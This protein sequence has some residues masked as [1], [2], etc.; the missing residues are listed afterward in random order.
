MANIVSDI[1]IKQRPY[2]GKHILID[3][4]IL[5]YQL[6]GQLDLSDELSSCASL[7]IS[8][9]TVT[10]LYAGTESEDLTDM[11][12]F[13]SEFNVLPLTKE[14][15]ELAGMYAAQLESKKYKDYLIA[16]TAHMHNLHLVSANKKD[17]FGLPLKKAIWVHMNSVK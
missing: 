15:A 12:D 11:R 9:I 2:R 10:E 4:N 1:K 17:F 5:I 14:V 7:N 6:T 3:T 8:A 13:V 16:A